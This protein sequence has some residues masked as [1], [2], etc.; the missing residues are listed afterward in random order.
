VGLFAC[1]RQKRSTLDIGCSPGES[2]WKRENGAF[3][4]DRSGPKSQERGIQQGHRNQIWW[5]IKSSDIM[6]SWQEFKQ[7]ESRIRK[8]NVRAEAFKEMPDHFIRLCFLNNGREPLTRSQV[9]DKTEWGTRVCAGA[10]LPLKKVEPELLIDHSQRYEKGLSIAFRWPI[11]QYENGEKGRNGSKIIVNVEERKREARWQKRN[12]CI[13]R[14]LW[15]S[16]GRDDSESLSILWLTKS[17]NTTPKY[18]HHKT[19]WFQTELRRSDCLRFDILCFSSHRF[20]IL[21]IPVGI[22]KKKKTSFH[23]IWSLMNRRS[24]QIMKCIQKV[25][26]WSK[27]PQKFIVSSVP[28]SPSNSLLISHKLYFLYL[29][30]CQVLESLYTFTFPLC[31]R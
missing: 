28:F 27:L 29:I 21:L 6:V 19:V 14:T 12:E 25:W 5:K 3:E 18:E 13:D 7:I 9:T 16:H 22:Q 2:N 30:Q 24:E 4:F 1:A 8:K 17:S 15:Y 26:S 11:I 31:L 10:H 20:L 23:T